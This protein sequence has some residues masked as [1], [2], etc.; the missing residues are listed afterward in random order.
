MRARP[1]STSSATSAWT[2]CPGQDLARSR[3]GSISPTH[4]IDLARSLND[5]LGLGTRFIRSNIYDLPDVLDEQFDVVFTSYGVLV[6]AAR[7]RQVGPRL[8][9]II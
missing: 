2:P 4:A 5:E 3:Q 1:S 6:L 8:S 9:A 7:P